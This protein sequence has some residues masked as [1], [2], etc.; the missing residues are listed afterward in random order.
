MVAVWP[1]RSGVGW[2]CC[3]RSMA[4]TKERKEEHQREL[5]M[6]RES[7]FFG[8]KSAPRGHWEE[9]GRRVAFVQRLASLLGIREESD[10]KRVTDLHVKALGGTTLLRMF[11]GSVGRLL[12]DTGVGKHSARPAKARGWWNITENRRSFL[13]QLGTTMGVSTGEQWASVKVKSVLAAGGASLLNHYNGSLRAALQELLPEVD[14]PAK[15]KTFSWSSHEKQRACL[16]EVAAIV[17]VERIEHL[18]QVPRRKWLAVEGARSL[19]WKHGESTRRVLEALLDE[20][21][22]ARVTWPRKYNWRDASERRAFMRKIGEQW[23]VEKASDWARV[24]SSAVVEAG[25]SHLLNRLYKGSFFALLKDTFPE[26]AEES[27]KTLRPSATRGYWAVEG[28]SRAAVEEFARSNGI[29]SLEQWRG[30]SKQQ[31]AAAGLGGVVARQGT[32]VL[33]L[34]REAYGEDLHRSLVRPVRT[35]EHWDR[36]ETVVEFIKMAE[37]RM[38]LRGPE[39]W[40]RVAAPALK[41]L[42]GGHSF[43]THVG[44]ARALPLAFPAV[45]WDLSRFESTAPGK[46]AAQRLLF[47]GLRS[48]FCE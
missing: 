31:L 42:P 3:R 17:G 21:E 5:E 8:G 7:H 44:L 45:K 39:D 27:V 22:L 4:H 47:V 41:K 37:E 30:V 34:L 40:Y 28:H 24:P 33:G 25:G 2:L 16:E 19:L 9:E 26:F 20:E 35:A 14:M 36:D 10:W 13:V 43:F 38:Q 46:K 23:G 6:L 32:S 15:K 18:A 12:E 48:I 29:E 1:R 11:G